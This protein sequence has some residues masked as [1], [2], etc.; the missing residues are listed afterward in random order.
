MKDVDNE[1]CLKSNVQRKSTKQEQSKFRPL[2]KKTKTKK[3]EGKSRAMV[4]WA[5]CADLSHP[6]FAFYRKNP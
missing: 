1:Q 6:P 2:Q 5:S 4:E 3:P